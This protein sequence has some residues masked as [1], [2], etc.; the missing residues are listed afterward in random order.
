LGRPGERKKW[1]QCPGEK[2]I[3]GGGTGKIKVSGDGGG[4][5]GKR[6]VS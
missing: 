2:G 5:V 6:K 1:S 3:Y 4:D